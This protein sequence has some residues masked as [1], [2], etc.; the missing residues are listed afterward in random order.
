M[1]PDYQPSKH[2]TSSLRTRANYGPLAERSYRPGWWQFTIHDEKGMLTE[3][4]APG[5]VPKSSS[6]GEPP[7]YFIQ[8]CATTAGPAETFRFDYDIVDDVRHTFSHF[9]PSF[10]ASVSHGQRR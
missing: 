5:Q 2:W 4:F 8:V 6:P 3:A 1:G 9:S 7:T 10:V